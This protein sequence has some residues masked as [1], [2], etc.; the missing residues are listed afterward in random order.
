M[1]D[2]TCQNSSRS[3]SEYHPEDPETAWEHLEP[4]LE[5]ELPHLAVQA[6]ETLQT[7]EQL[8]HR[9]IHRSLGLL[10]AGVG[11]ISGRPRALVIPSYGHG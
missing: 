11:V 9:L 1:S 4:C 7:Y 10:E 6:H 8:E 5:D 2:F 3:L